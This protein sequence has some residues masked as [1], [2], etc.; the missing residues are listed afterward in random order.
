VT[1]GTRARGLR[2]I[3]AR[4]R[5]RWAIALWALASAC[6]L[7]SA[8]FTPRGFDP[9][10]PPQAIITG[11]TRAGADVVVVA[12]AGDVIASVVAEASGDFAVALPAGADG[13]ALRLYAR[14]GAWAAK[15][16][17]PT[18]IVGDV[19]DAGVVDATSTA[20]AQLAT[21]EIVQEAGSTFRA[22][23]PPALA[24][25]LSKLAAS[26]PALDAF[27][28]E[29]A[30]ALST[31]EALPTDAAPPFDAISF[32]LDE[33][34]LVA[35]G[36]GRDVLSSYRATL[37]A[38]AADFALEIRCDPA[39]LNVMFTVDLSGR[40]LDGNGAPQLIRQPPKE[41]R[42]FVGFT[43]DE[44]SPLTDA[45]IPRK[46]A[47]NDPTYAMVDDGSAGDEL[48]GD[49]IYTVVVAL[50]RGARIQ[51][52]YTDG[53]AGEGFTGAEEW[54]GNARILEIED[55]LSGRP[56]GEPDCLVVRRDSF[57]DEAS[58]KN[59]VNL[60]GVARQRG[61]AV[62]FDTDLGGDEVP[63]GRTSIRVGGLGRDDV[64]ARGT[65]TPRGVPEAR[66]NGVCTLCPAPL[67]LDPDDAIAPRLVRADRT[68]NDRVR[69]RFSEPMSPDDVRALDRWLYV[70]EAGLAIP[71]LSA[72]PSGTDVLLITAPT[73]PRTPARLVVRDLRDASVRGNPIED[74]GE[75]RRLTTDMPEGVFACA[76]VGPD[77]TPPKLLAARALSILDVDPTANVDDPT[78]GDL[79]ELTFDER[80]EPSSAGDVGRYRI[81]GLDVLAAVLLEPEDAGSNVHR[82]RLVTDVQ[83]KSVPYVVRLAGLRD[84]AGNAIDQEAD[85]DGFALYRVRFSVVPGFA[86]QDSAGMV[87]G[88]PRGERLYLTGTPLAAARAIDGHDLS[89][90]SMGSARTDV[91]GWP[92]FELTATS[93]RHEGQP[94]YGLS[95]LLPRGSWA[96]KAAHGVEGEYQS[97]PPTLEKVYKTLAT[98]N[99]G[100]GVRVD[101]ATM[102]AENGLEYSGARLSEGG[103]EP[104]RQSVVFK[105]EAPDEVCEVASDVECPF[106][107]VGAWRDLS[108]EA[109]GRLRDYDDGL[110][111][112][113][114]HRPTLPDSAPPKLLD[115][116]AR[117]SFSVLLSFDEALATSSQG[118]TV[119]L[120]RAE[121]GFGLPVRLVTSA[122][123]RP[124]QA[125]V[126]VQASSCDGAMLP[127]VA[128]A[129]RHRGATDRAGLVERRVR[130]QTVLAPERCVPLTPLADRAAPVVTEALATDLTEVTVRFDER[131]DPAT[132]SV[133]TNYEIRPSGGGAELAIASA[134]VL[135]DRASV[136]LVTAPQQI[137][138]A[139]TLTVS[140]ISDAA[141]P[142]NVLATQ[143]IELAGFGERRPPQVTRAR[144]IAADRVLVRFDEPVEPTTALDVARYRIDGLTITRVEFSGD[145]ARRALAFNPVLAPRIREAVLLH[146]TPMSAGAGYSVVVDGVRD[147]SGNPGQS[148]VSFSGVSTAPLVDV[149][150]EYRVSDTERI[151][152]SVPARAISLATLSE[153]REGVFVLGARQGV[154][155]RPVTGR[156]APVNDVLGGFGVEGQAL[157]G[158][159]PRLSDNGAP[160]DL[161]AGDGIFSIVVP[162]VP[163]GTTII[164][165]AFASFSTQYR[166]RNP[167]DT[168]A[169]FA[170][171]LPGPSTFTDGQEFPGNE[172]GALVLDD[173]S[174]D[175]VV[176][177]R[178]LFGDELTY[179]KSTGGAAFVWVFD[180]R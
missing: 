175:G 95:M 172:N 62:S 13:V 53:A 109:S 36:Q 52:K 104:P 67:V 105:R 54:P 3:G 9:S 41:G 83:G 59:F 133:S 145:P 160:P 26:T 74:G 28:A 31:A 113:A 102:I 80:P 6:G 143:S 2:T 153:S 156:D 128:Y 140:R 19:T 150:L 142:A 88:I 99:D 177:I 66:E 114:P 21:Y 79:V 124:H 121:D 108:P 18:T 39:R 148:T 85:F 179:K 49:G 130:V 38:A 144:A 106:I 65:L 20:R 37:G 75:C 46:L 73:N 1:R 171:G 141:D 15:A 157:D 68:A 58:N 94:I 159:E 103:D 71:V 23:P 24:G 43:S 125:V 169:A 63:V 178:C 164:W 149:V 84:T 155:G 180:D 86:F 22:T 8:L 69:V 78:T 152:G 44:S 45:A 48:A 174:S 25:L 40:G 55:V 64:R 166:D 35:A 4:R 72:T 135:P 33:A 126:E 77:T 27:T 111:P 32:E 12:R 29:V 47:P 14:A 60:N 16:I 100:T 112:L 176:R 161:A 93:E 101:P 10:D 5:A 129:V 137:L 70:D 138:A 42:A 110:V 165:K 131:I 136:R 119:E 117:D 57:G 90:T 89:V 56:D 11:T 82:V 115:A 96:W 123:L 91:T 132:A 98:T 50:P 87:R 158:I 154:D 34:F 147:L 134:E 118:L 51:Y 107:V 81:D 17:V 167:A 76:L 139:Y 162:R 170:D 173:G 116:R 127:G 30:R 120:A 146:T 122:E 97:P 163:L 92:Q 151:A 168:L 7:D 61:G